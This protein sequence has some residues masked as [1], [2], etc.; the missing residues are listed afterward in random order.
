MRI[1]AFGPHPDDIEFLCAGT[2]AEAAGVEVEEYFTLAEPVL[3]KGN[4]LTGQ[5]QIWAERLRTLNP[6]AT[7]MIAYYGRSNGWLDDQIAVSIKAHGTGLIYY[8]GAYFD[9]AAQRVLMEHLPK[10]ARV[11]TIYA[12]ARVEICTLQAVDGK[13]IYLVINHKPAEQ[14]LVMPWASYNHLS[15]HEIRADFKLPPYGVAIL[16]PLTAIASLKKHQ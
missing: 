9:K 2:L 6:R 12:P 5:A 3:V 10:T 7:S 15:G 16:I 1:M 14:E 13:E 8:V 4:W 11:T